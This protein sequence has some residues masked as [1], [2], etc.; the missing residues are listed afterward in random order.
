MIAT[1]AEASTFTT[2]TTAWCDGKTCSAGSH[3]QSHTPLN[4]ST[5]PVLFE[6]CRPDI[7]VK[8][9]NTCTCMAALRE[10]LNSQYNIVGF[11]TIAFHV[12][13]TQI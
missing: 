7:A 9:V 13:F 5:G 4:R 3:A 8:Y 1:T 10:Q 2:S 11:L 6:S 12:L